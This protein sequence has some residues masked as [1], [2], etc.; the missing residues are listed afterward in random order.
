MNPSEIV[1]SDYVKD[2][3]AFHA[4]RI[5]RNYPMLRGEREDIAQELWHA[6]L[7]RV[8]GYDPK[9]GTVETFCARIFESACKQITRKAMARKRVALRMAAP[10]NFD[11]LDSEMGRCRSGRSGEAGLGLLDDE[12]H[13]LA[14]DIER[15]IALMDIDGFRESL[16]PPLDELFEALMEGMS[17]CDIMR[18]KGMTSWHLYKRMLPLLQELCK[19]K[20]REYLENSTNRPPSP[21]K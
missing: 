18:R 4:R 9:R 5:A 12:G 1:N 7:K 8:D 14:K 10:L 17:P 20:L 2:A 21:D 3:I 11:T 13:Y 16:P 19:G 15:A 6:L